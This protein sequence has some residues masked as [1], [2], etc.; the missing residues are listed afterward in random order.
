MLFFRSDQVDSESIEGSYK[1]CE[2]RKKVAF[3][4]T[5]KCAS[6][7]IQN[8]LLR[9]GKNNNLNFVLPMKGNI[10][11][12]HVPFHRSMIKGTLWEEAKLD[13]HMFLVHTRWNL[14]EI[15]KIL[16]D[17]G[18]VIYVSILRDP[19][20]LF[21]S[22]W[23]YLRLDKRY[24]QTIENYAMTGRKEELESKKGFEKRPYGINQMLFDFG[25]DVEDMKDK[26]KI[27]RKIVDIDET[28]DIILIADDDSFDDSI[29]LLKDALCWEYRDM[30]N[31]K[32]NSEKSE[33]KSFLS[34]TA[35]QVLK[36][37]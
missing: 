12:N 6:T 16:N 1:G 19:V 36:G 4:K 14:P 7:S 25:M 34:A 9:F 35:R 5:H 13:Y 23:D 33:K 37:N 10:L 17:Q 8:I 2:P 3:L 15:S 30:I 11:G 26:E 27:E 32:L 18:D 22:W 29:V 21:R 28:F 31:F 20:E 24:N